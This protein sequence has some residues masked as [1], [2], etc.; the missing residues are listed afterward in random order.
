MAEKKNERQTQS[1][2]MMAPPPSYF[3]KRH[4]V[5]GNPGSGPSTSLPA[6]LLGYMHFFAKRYGA[7]IT[8]GCYKGPYC[9]VGTLVVE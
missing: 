3:K 4:V 7:P 9:R 5:D 2:A 6:I 8:H 1:I